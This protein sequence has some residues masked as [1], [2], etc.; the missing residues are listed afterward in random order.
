MADFSIMD[1]LRR[2]MGG[3]KKPHSVFKNEEEALRFCRDAYQKSGGI[4]PELQRA[5]EYYQ[6]HVEDECLPKHR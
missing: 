4:T 6:Q 2:A 5:F 3:D 1:I